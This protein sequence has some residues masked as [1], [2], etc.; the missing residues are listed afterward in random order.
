MPNRITLQL[1][2]HWMFG[3][4][5]GNNQPHPVFPL[6]Y[7]WATEGRCRLPLSPVGSRLGLGRAVPGG[8]AQ[9]DRLVNGGQT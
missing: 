6:P 4:A 2:A 3:Q 1:A 8:R 7:Q 5:V 9:A